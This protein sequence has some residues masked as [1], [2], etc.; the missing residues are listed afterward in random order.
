MTDET[1]KHQEAATG[2]G[3]ASDSFSYLLYV[4]AASYENARDYAYK[5]GYHYSR[6]VN[7]CRVEKLRGLRGIEMHVLPCAADRKN[8]REIMQEAKTRQTKFRYI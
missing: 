6:M 8:Y 1:Q 3:E 4:I 5:Q 2:S 7:V